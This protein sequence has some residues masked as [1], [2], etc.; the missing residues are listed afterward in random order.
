MVSRSATSLMLV[1]VGTC[2][3]LCRASLLGA[4]AGTDKKGQV[5]QSA[6]PCCDHRD[7]SSAPVPVDPCENV[8]CFCSPFVMHDTS[9]DIAVSI[10]LTA[11]PYLP[12]SACVSDL[13][14]VPMVRAVPEHHAFPGDATEC[15]PA[16]PLLI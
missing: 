1:L 5:F 8:S 6:D 3:V 2:P 14:P 10:L 15:P 12:L 16:L 11:T 4:P 9:S 13:C 7:Q